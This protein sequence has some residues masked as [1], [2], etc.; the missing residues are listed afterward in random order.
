MKL[1]RILALGAGLV[2]VYGAGAYVLGAGIFGIYGPVGAFIAMVI[3]AV[4]AY[5]FGEHEGREHGHGDGYQEGW[6]QAT[7]HYM[8]VIHGKDAADK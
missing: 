7:D 3:L 2:L 5:K 8:E 6:R 4:A 1:L